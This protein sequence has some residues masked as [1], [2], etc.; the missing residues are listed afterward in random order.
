MCR[1]S[2]LIIFETTF[3]GP[4]VASAL[5]LS[6][7]EFESKYGFPKPSKDSA[8]VTHCRKGGRGRRAADAFRTA[9]YTN[10]Q[11]SCGWLDWNENNG[12]VEK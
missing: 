10:V 8:V 7:A 5:E 2:T 11:L 1:L 6:D 12:P 4:Q 9:G 3:P